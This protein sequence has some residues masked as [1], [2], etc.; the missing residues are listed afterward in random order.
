MDPS[1]WAAIGA[2]A[3]GIIVALGGVAA[4]WK[5][6]DRAA[7][8]ALRE[9]LT[10]TREELAKTRDDLLMAEASI[11]RQKRLLRRHGI[12]SDEEL[13]TGEPPARETEAAD[14]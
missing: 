4:Q 7:T 12:M 14:A 9:D 5:G 6:A 13:E 11:F 2:S 10:E 3:S 8:K 1:A